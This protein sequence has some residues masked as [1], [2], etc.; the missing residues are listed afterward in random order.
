MRITAF[1]VAA[2]IGLFAGPARA[3]AIDGAWCG[4]RGS[5]KIDGP[6]IRIPSGAEISGDY[7]RHGFHYVGPSGDPEAGIEVYMR[8]HSEESMSLRRVIGGVPGEAEAWRRCQ[9]TS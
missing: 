4:P 8:Q 7:D 6:K 9:V 1:L 5:L 2:A 3:D